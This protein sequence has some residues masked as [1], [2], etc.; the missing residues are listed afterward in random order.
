MLDAKNNKKYS[1]TSKRPLKFLSLI[2]NM[3]KS[4]KKNFFKLF[5]CIYKKKIWCFKDTKRLPFS[6][7]FNN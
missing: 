6:K 5:L 3:L 1:R 4:F 2:K 7:V